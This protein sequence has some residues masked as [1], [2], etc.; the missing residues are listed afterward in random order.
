MIR[1][2]FLCIACKGY[3]AV[4]RRN[5]KLLSTHSEIFAEGPQHVG[6]YFPSVLGGIFIEQRLH[7]FYGLVSELVRFDDSLQKNNLAANARRQIQALFT[8]AAYHLDN[9][10]TFG[11]VSLVLDEDL[12]SFHGRV[13]I[14]SVL[15]ATSKY[16]KER[17]THR[18]VSSGPWEHSSA[19]F[20]IQ[21]TGEARLAT[22]LSSLN[23]NPAAVVA[24]FFKEEIAFESK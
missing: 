21:L 3:A 13:R 11:L 14:S 24:I 12:T 18:S 8:V 16:R 23:W 7:D 15:K 9:E 1:H 17:L 19:Y 2:H 20:I 5:F 22:F 4:L 6:A 10:A